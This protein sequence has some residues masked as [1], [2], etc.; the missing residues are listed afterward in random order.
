MT[1]LGGP[2]MLFLFNLNF[3]LSHVRVGERGLSKALKLND[4]DVCH[5]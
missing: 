1:R 2:V 5:S 4:D 3:T